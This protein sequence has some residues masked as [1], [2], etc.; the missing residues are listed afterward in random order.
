MRALLVLAFL[1]VSQPFSLPARQARLPRVAQRAQRV[2]LQEIEPDE[3][4]PGLD[5][6]SPPPREELP[7]FTRRFSE[8][9]GPYTVSHGVP[10]NETDRNPPFL[11][12]QDWHISG[13]YDLEKI[14]E[15][16]L[17]QQ[18]DV[19]AVVERTEEDK[20]E[21]PFATKE[22][23]QLEFGE[24]ADDGQQP[25]LEEPK[26]ATPMPSSW[27]EFQ[28]LQQSV[29]KYAQGTERLPVPAADIAHA[30]D[31][32]EKLDEIYPVFKTVISEGWDFVFDPDIEQAGV[33][34]QR[35]RKWEESIGGEKKAALEWDLEGEAQP[36]VGE[37]THD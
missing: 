24:P 31:F 5:V 26:S 35:M 25:H 27:Q 23:M 13:S 8:G 33:F 9:T 16:G 15:I 37:N 12:N 14:A 21:D 32:V 19:D 4:I 29:A 10:I 20:R 2:V 30:E 17:R 11:T 22:Y 6:N 1:P 34:V 36:Y 7:G 28:F 18:A 3:Y